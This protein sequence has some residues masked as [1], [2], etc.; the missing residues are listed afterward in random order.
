MVAL[1]NKLV[2]NSNEFR[3][4]LE[5]GRELKKII[6]EDKIMKASLVAEHAEALELFEKH[7]Q[8]KDVK[9]VEWRPW[10]K[11]LLKYLNNPT[12]RRIIWVVGGKGNE[13]KNFFQGQIRGQYGR[14]RVCKMNLKG[15]SK[16]ILHHMRKVVDIP[17]DIFLFNIQKGV[18]M[19][20]IDYT[21]LEDIKD[22]EALAE[23]YETMIVTFTTPNVIIVFGN[24]YPDTG[25]TLSPDRWLI[26]KI[27]ARMELE[28]VTEAKLNKK[29]GGG[30]IQ[31]RI[32]TMLMID[33]ILIREIMIL[34]D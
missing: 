9:P 1:R 10:Q 12:D 30:G 24:K 16:D 21:L 5:L 13:G 33:G 32:E 26:F 2:N 15:K 11:G 22:G 34:T 31:T 28:D 18:I 8:D 14:H 3:R 25:T 20:D 17:T 6:T 7:G 19:G 27:N 4:K 29:R 23:K